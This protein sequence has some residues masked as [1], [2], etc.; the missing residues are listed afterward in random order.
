MLSSDHKQQLQ[1]EI[2]YYNLKINKYLIKYKNLFNE[3]NGG[4]GELNEE[5]PSTPKQSVTLD[6]PDAPTKIKLESPSQLSDNENRLVTSDVTPVI[7]PVNTPT[8]LVTPIKSNSDSSSDE[9]ILFTP[10]S[11]PTKLVTPGA[12]IKNKLDTLSNEN[13][14]F[15]PENTPTKLVTPG[16]PIKRKKSNA[17]DDDTP[18][19]TPV[20]N[21]ENNKFLQRYLDN[22][23]NSTNSDSITTEH[24]NGPTKD[25]KSNNVPSLLFLI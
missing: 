10:E 5:L 2:N 21:K 9:Y 24:N 12:P 18:K 4:S 7:T 11:T 15:T 6:A 23:N 19:D 16:A 22:I 17:S 8:K 20:N 25:S 14:L 13:I 3:I 1:N